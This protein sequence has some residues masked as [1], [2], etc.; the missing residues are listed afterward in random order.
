MTG[1]P[2]KV[3]VITG[4]AS[5]I[6]RL[7]ATKLARLG[8]RV[9]IYDLDREKIDE[10]VAEIRA[11]GGDAYGHVC[12]VSDREAVYETAEKVRG[13]VGHADILINNAGII[14]GKPLMDIPDEKIEATMKV[15]VLALFWTTK[16]FLPEMLARNSGHIVTMASAAGLLG[17]SRQTDYAASKHAA[18]GF[19]ESLRVELKKSG[20][21][22]IT[23]TI[24]EPFYVDTGMFEGVKVRPGVGLPI[25]SPDY[26]AEQTVRAIQRDKQEVPLPPRIGLTPVLRFLP[27]KLFDRIMDL[28][29]VNDSMERFVGRGK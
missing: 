19:T 5:G 16:S 14:S 7:L 22:G 11:A 12:D 26:V 10:A 20:H 4:G 17:V 1:I 3:I 21:G 27:T 13:E 15:N 25:L 28:L 18:I 6:G 24:I 8:G 29:G 23:T 9:V 2:G